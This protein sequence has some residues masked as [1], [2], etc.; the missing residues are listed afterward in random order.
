MRCVIVAHPYPHAQEE[1]TLLTEYA[2]TRVQK[3]VSTIHVS[4]PDLHKDRRVKLNKRQKNEINSAHRDPSDHV[5]FS[6]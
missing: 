4:L 6:D 2:F 1:T 5:E 3:Y